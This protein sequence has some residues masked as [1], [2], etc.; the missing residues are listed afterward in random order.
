MPVFFTMV[1]SASTGSTARQAVEN[2]FLSLNRIPMEASA[3]AGSRKSTKRL[4]M[5]IL[6]LKNAMMEQ[7][8]P[9]SAA[10]RKRF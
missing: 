10:S 1:N 9:S 6:M 7:P 5:R 2:R 8:S 3:S 4:L